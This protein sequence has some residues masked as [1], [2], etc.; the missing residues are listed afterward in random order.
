MLDRWLSYTVTTVAKFARVDSALVVLDE[1]SYYRGGRLNRFDCNSFKVLFLSYAAN[2][3][4]CT[5]FFDDRN[6]CFKCIW[7]DVT[8]LCNPLKLPVNFKPS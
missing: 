4:I 6:I 7:I 5:W 1:W 2:Q 3:L 8:E